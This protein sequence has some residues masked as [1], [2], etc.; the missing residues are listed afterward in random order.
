MERWMAL[1]MG[2]SL[3]A[4]AY[5]FVRR[6]GQSPDLDAIKNVWQDLKIDA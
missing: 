1:K 5:L 2:Q 4:K 3:N 6:S